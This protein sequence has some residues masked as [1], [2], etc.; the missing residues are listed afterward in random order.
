MK[1]SAALLLLALVVLGCKAKPKPPPPPAYVP[2]LAQI[3]ASPKTQKPK[4]TTETKDASTFTFAD[5]DGFK[6]LQ[7]VAAK[8]HPKGWKLTFESVG[9][10]VSPFT[11]EP[12]PDYGAMTVSTPTDWFQI[13]GGPL[14]GSV[15]HLAGY[16]ASS[17]QCT[18]AEVFSPDFF[19]SSA[20]AFQEKEMITW[21]CES[22]TASV[23][24]TSVS[25]FLDQCKDTARAKLS[26]PDT[27]DFHSLGI[28][29][30]VLTAADCTH[31]WHSD[32]DSKNAFNATQ[33]HNFSC[34]TNKRGGVDVSM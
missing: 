15:A 21:A 28:A 19:L 33:K 22:G 34:V 13:T 20:F 5:G 9:A 16:M 11:F 10:K 26:R 17:D 7:L 18:K 6:N 29:H 24:G 4:T 23:K 14:K 1:T 12:A 2:T 27:A 3:A 31:G 32:V 8:D 25:A 30:E